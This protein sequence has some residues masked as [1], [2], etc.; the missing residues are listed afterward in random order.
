MKNTLRN[1]ITISMWALAFLWLPSV[2]QARTISSN[3]TLSSIPLSHAPSAEV[4]DIAQE[5]YLKSSGTGSDD[6]ED[7]HAQLFNGE[8]GND[9]VDSSDP[10]EVDMGSRSSITVHFDLS[11]Y[12]KGFDIKNIRILLGEKISPKARA[13]Q[14]YSVEFTFLN[15]TTAEIRPKT[16]KLDPSSSYWSLVSFKDGNDGIMASRVKSVTF[17]LSHKASGKNTAIVREIDILGSPSDQEYSITVQSPNG[18]RIP[19]ILGASGD[20]ALKTG[21]DYFDWFGI[22]EHRTWFKPTFSDLTNDKNVNT[23]EAFVKASEKIRKDP[24]KQATS[25]DNFIDWKHF[26]DQF[27]R[28][29]MRQKIAHLKERNIRPLITNTTFI[30]QKPITDDWVKRFQYW[31]YWYTIVYHL[32]SEHDV[33]MYAFRNEPHAKGDYDTWESHW[34]MCADAMRKAMEDVNRD[35]NKSL[36]INICG[37]NCPGVYWDK[38]FSHPSEDIHCWG[39]VSWKKVKYDVFGK[40]NANN[41][42]NYSSYHFHRYGEDAVRTKEIILNARKDIANADNDANDD[43]PLVITEFNTS[44]GGNFDR[45]KLDTEDLLYGVSLAQVL[46]STAVHG[47]KGLGND[48]GLFAFKLAG[49]EGDLPLVGV[50]N[51]LCYIGHKGPKNYGGITRGGACFQMYARHFSGG[52]P[53][54]PVKTNKGE[55]TKRRT[56]AVVDEENRAYYI[57]GSNVTDPVE[58]FIDLSALK[59]TPGTLASLQ[60]VGEKNTGQITEILTLSKS[61]TLQFKTPKL[62]AFL[63]KIPMSQSLSP[64]KKVAP[65]QDSTVTVLETGAH[66]SEPTMKVSIHHSDAAQRQAG[67]LRFE[68]NNAKNPGK[69]L[70]GLSG[71]NTGKDAFKREILHVYAVE[72]KDWNEI[73]KIKWTDAPGL[74]R[75]HLGKND[76]EPADGTGDMVD[77]EDN[78]RGYTTDEGTGLGI[79]GKFIGAVSFYSPEFTTNYLDVTDYLKSVSEKDRNV[80]VTFVVARIVR[81]NVNEYE[82]SYYKIGEYHYD[83]RAVEIAT[84]EHSDKSLHPRLIYAAEAKR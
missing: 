77:I 82:N 46:E 81:Y 52:K 67:L 19:K 51:K 17:T 6:A 75:Y 26:R 44:T 60:Q 80:D 48:G 41:P 28:R 79:H 35:F 12:N 27:K 78:Y 49:S 58:T 33:T 16:V 55:S 59:V 42:M 71:R 84:K 1:P 70:L 63:I 56:L 22:T 83:G 3:C 4:T 9:D 66:G 61:K 34:L 29:D 10:G 18:Y 23:A 7:K 31:R 39:R 20:F 37:A 54:L 30:D 53:L 21:Y 76:L 13:N 32:A 65:S 47:P 8:V 38:R 15:N 25:K 72:N 68:I 64:Y 69:A 50:G 2:G 14:K 57:Y 11:Q 5:Y 45:R 40:Y 62:S 74:G 73:K 43:I 36:K 24:L